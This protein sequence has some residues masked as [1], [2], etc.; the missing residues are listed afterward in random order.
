MESMTA[1]SA[2]RNGGL[3]VSGPLAAGL[4]L[5][6]T[7]AS[8]RAHELRRLLRLADISAGAV[9][10]LAAGA[11]AGIPVGQL[12]IVVASLAVAWPLLSFVC[13]LHTTDDL[14]S[15]ASGAAE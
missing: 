11:V 6:P 14:R 8:R 9:A 7:T 4:H 1:T 15:W 12:A 3:A 5:K 13:G 2:D 10:G